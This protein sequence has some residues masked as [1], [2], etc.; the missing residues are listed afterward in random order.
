MNRKNQIRILCRWLRAL[1]NA[2]GLSQE[3]VASAIGIDVGN[4]EKER[5]EPGIGNLMELIDYYG[6]SLPWL[7]QRVEDVDAGLVSE[8]EFMKLVCSHVHG[9]KPGRSVL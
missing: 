7:L 5:S 2:K 6:L 1:R 8:E 9:K 4:Y 3:Q